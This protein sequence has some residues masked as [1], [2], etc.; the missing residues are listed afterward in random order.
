ML[1]GSGR[2]GAGRGLLYLLFGA[3]LPGI[4]IL[5]RTRPAQLAPFKPVPRRERLDADPSHVAPAPKNG[6][7]RAG[8]GDGTPLG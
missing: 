2:F 1:M 8:F 5:R 4:L 6:D 7:P 3:A